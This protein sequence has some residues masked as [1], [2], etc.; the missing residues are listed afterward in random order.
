MS[1]IGSEIIRLGE[2]DSTNRY[3]M[4]LLTKEKPAEGTVIIADAQTAG[5]GLDGTTWESTPFMNLTFSFLVYPDFLAPDEQFYLNKAVSLGLAEAVNEI[6]PDQNEITIKWP[7]DIYI[8]DKKLAGTLIQNGVKGSHF[9]FAVIGIGLNVNQVGFPASVSNPVSIKQLGGKEFDLDKVFRI[10]TSHLNIRYDQL[11][12]GSTQEIDADYLA[13]LYRF[14]Q[15]S[16]FTFKGKPIQGRIMG[17]NRYGQLIVEIPGE[18]IIECD[19]KEI[20]FNI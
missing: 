3:F 17:V 12:R 20:S 2:V 15:L 10:V 19:L 6:L 1:I 4:D 11:K 8:G 9:E 7:N 13:H 18:K 16:G 14:R 5:R